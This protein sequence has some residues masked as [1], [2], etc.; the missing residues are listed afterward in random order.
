MERHPRGGGN[1]SLGFATDDLDLDVVGLERQLAS[2]A[3]ATATTKGKRGRKPGQK[4]FKSDMKNKLE[5][6]RQSARECR[7]RKKLRYFHK[8]HS[9]GLQ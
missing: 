4:S 1:N 5:R 9:I 2:S 8:T 7:A 3:V 6:S